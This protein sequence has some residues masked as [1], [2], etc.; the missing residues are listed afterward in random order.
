MVGAVVA[1]NRTPQAR[2]RTR[3]SRRPSVQNRDSKV[4]AATDARTLI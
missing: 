4:D 1:E 2:V 3:E